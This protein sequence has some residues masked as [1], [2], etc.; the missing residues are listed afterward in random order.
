MTLSAKVKSIR[1]HL[2]FWF[3]GVA[4]LGVV[5][6]ATAD[7]D[8]SLSTWKSDDGL[9][10]NHVTGIAQ[11]PDGY[12]WV[13]TF[14]KPARFDGVRFD[15]LF[16]R[17]Y[18]VAINQKITALQLARHGLW[19]GTSH[20]QVIYSDSSGVRVFTN[21]LPDKVVDTLTEDGGGA[22][23][24]GCQSGLV[25]RIKD[26]QVRSFTG[27]DGLPMG[28]NPRDY[29]CSLALDE[30]GRIWFAKNGQ[31]GM[32][33][34]DRFETLLKLPVV[35]ARLARAKQGGIWICSGN[36]LLKYHEGG[37]PENLGTF[38]TATPVEP[39]SLLEDR[40][41]GLWIGT[42]DGGL[43]RYADGK[44]E[45]VP[46][47][48]EQI[49]C[50][51]EDREGDIWAGTYSGGMDRLQQRI[52]DLETVKTGLP[53]G[54]VQS[55]CQDTRGTIWAT[56]QTGLLLRRENAMWTTVSSN[57]NWPGGSAT[58]V[59]ADPSG[60][61]WIGTR[62]HKLICLRNGRFTKLE[63]DDGVAGRQIHALW[64]SR[65][66]DVWIGEESPDVVQRLHEGKLETFQSPEKTRIIRSMT[67][68][69][70]GNVW[71]GTS[72]GVLLKIRDGALSDETAGTS[73]QPLSIRCLAA[74]ADGGLWIGYA[75]EGLG[76]LKNGHYFHVT[77]SQ[78]FPEENVSQ[79]VTDDEG[80]LWFG[81]DHGI[82]KV[83]QDELE[84]LALGTKANANYIHYGQSE[85]LFSLEANCGDSPGALRDAGGR[86]WIP[87]R[88]ALAVANPQSRS[89]QESGPPPVLLR[90]VADGDQTLAT[91]GGVMPVREGLDLSK[92]PVELELPPGRHRVEFDFTALSFSAPENV[93]FRYRLDGVDDGWIDGGTQRSARY[94][95]L[96]AG[97]Y[98]FSVQACNSRGVWN[99]DGPSLAVV[100]KPFLWQT[101]W[102]RPAA[103]AI[104]TAFVVAIARYI[105]FGRLR[106]KLQKL[107]Q[108]AALD[109]ERAR[110][111][112]DI[113]DDLG[114]RL[115]E[116]ELLLESANRTPP[117]KLNGQIHKISTTV[118]Q[119][120]ESLDEI[121]WAVN[122]RH[123]TL[124]RLLDYLGHYA[125]EFLQTANIRCRVDFP[126]DPPLQPVPPEVR[127]NLFLSVKEALNNVGRHSQA[128]ELWLRVSLSER[129]LKIFIE[130]NG[131][132]FDGAPKDADDD[133]LRNM[134]RRMVEIGGHFQ[135]ETRPGAGT[136][137]S[138]TLP[139]PPN[140]KAITP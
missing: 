3:G 91:Y 32:F 76:W 46:T 17:D 33:R 79:I 122:P 20:G 97:N 34:N 78:G 121:V 104:F 37:K 66:G 49:T 82:F 131:K 81:G 135:I 55:L 47:S 124:P 28:A 93:R 12:L 35:T 58:C 15:D 69:S 126:D 85:G 44:F 72:G 14:S 119:A 10:N 23:W 31:V 140:E 139:W 7:S 9:P 114:G 36:E 8:W 57:A 129:E 67:E 94:S 70:S 39:T 133:G 13:A 73:G 52:V 22:V 62:N 116:V 5:M 16:L 88:N 42:A 80:W 120:G 128:T 40:E 83:R 137:I 48:D 105:S 87:M 138:L 77:S 1:P 27:Q 101:W 127:H 106:L 51:R 117:E 53:D 100:V 86:L 113:H 125:I 115:T 61:I 71:V 92:R 65:N 64:I 54:T 111:A 108:Q 26:G 41:G 99:D 90:R 112:R 134:Q 75:D 11:T 18:S 107:E 130:D 84:Q 45:K 89:Q 98:V 96:A 136:R 6:A 2:R 4:L 68:D 38:K 56:T 110:I 59:A 95:R 74:A 21:G 30:Q 25:S 19:M 24:V 109:K 63:S 29:V 118:R 43:F 50:L 132:G 102:F 60:A 103:L 123:D